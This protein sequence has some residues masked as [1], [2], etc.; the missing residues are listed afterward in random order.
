MGIAFYIWCKSFWSLRKNDS[1]W[2]VNRNLQ[3]FRKIINKNQS[4]LFFFLAIQN[5]MREIT[6]RSVRRIGG[7]HTPSFIDVLWY[8][9]MTYS[10]ITKWI[11]FYACITWKVS[12]QAKL[13]IYLL[14]S[15]LFLYFKAWCL[16]HCFFLTDW[17][18][19]WFVKKRK[20]FHGNL[21]K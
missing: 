6:R 1:I 14:R 8:K 3:T 12:M 5:S 20:C 15:T 11:N 16:L 4:V 9:Q 10:D 18:D 13:S 2:I 17:E 21:K 19:L 7:N